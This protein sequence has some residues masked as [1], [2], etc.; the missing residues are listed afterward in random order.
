MARSSL[1]FVV[2]GFFLLLGRSNGHTLLFYPCSEKTHILVHLKLATE[3][4]NRNHTVYF[5]T[6][7]CLEDFSAKAAAD[8][9]PSAGLQFITYQM[10]CTY[11]EE[12]KRK[13]QF[14]NPVRAVLAILNNVFGRADDV[15]SNAALMERLQ[16]LAPE[17][18]FMVNDILSYG[19]LLS[20]KLNKQ[21]VDIDVGTAGALWEAVFHG[22]EPATSYVPAV[23]TFFPTN[24]M[25]FWQRAANLLVIKVLRG[26]VSNLYWH[27]NLWLQQLIKKHNIDMQWPYH[28]Y[29]MMLVN[30]NFITEPPRAIPPNIKYVGPIIP[31][32]PRPL[33]PQLQDW[34][35]GSGPQGTVF[36][37]FG[38]T[39]ELPAAASRTLIQV[40]RAMPD[41]R[42]IWKL[43]QEAQAE[44]QQ[45]LGNLSNAYISDW[46]PQNDLLGHPKV[47]AFITQG[48]YL[49]MAEAAYHAVPIIGLPFIPGQ[50]EL[51]RFAQDQGWAKRLPANTLLSGRADLL[52]QALAGMLENSSYKQA[53]AITSK[54]LRAA[55]RPYKQEAADWVEYAA[56]L[57]E[58]G[59]FLHPQKVYQYWYQ[60]VMIDV[61]LLYA[62]VAAVPVVLVWRWW[63]VQRYSYAARRGTN[64]IVA[65][66][67]LPGVPKQKSL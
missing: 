47:S 18:D 55:P 46:L 58:Y 19:M 24:G 15:L 6:P 51:I 56:S 64:T 54:R 39:L 61:L 29:M 42:F 40:I 49:S 21:Y 31:E 60:Q 48:G 7:D 57:R 23:G 27:P 33:P 52:Q 30:S 17:I 1:L 3:L 59:P 4:A 63:S 38:G 37:S 32:E 62:A 22:A 34:I 36:V 13:Y 12:E 43:R 25:S 16:Q 28:H 2:M 53:A 67:V 5:M 11:H 44:V 9:A 26:G 65:R 45:E 66:I 8:M 50:G 10:N 20:K 14:V 35:D 41:V